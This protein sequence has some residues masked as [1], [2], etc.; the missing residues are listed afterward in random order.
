M[1]DCPRL[2]LSLRLAPADTFGTLEWILANARRTGV[3]LE[4]LHWQSPAQGVADLSVLAD[5]DGPLHLLLRRLEN[6]VD[7]DV[8]AAE[9]DEP[10]ALAA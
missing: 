4:S 1:Q 10:V 9:F 6:G 7:L 2:R 3:R 5:N 8:L